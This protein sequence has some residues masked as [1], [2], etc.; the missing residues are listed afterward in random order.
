MERE[1]FPFA[2]VR[3]D[4]VFYIAAESL[5]D[6]KS[7]IETLN[8]CCVNV[9]RE[10]EYIASVESDIQSAAMEMKMEKERLLFP[11]KAYLPNEGNRQ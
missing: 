7:W 11:T 9:N 10:N 4:R 2:I 1:A 3:K 5:E 6:M 8:Q